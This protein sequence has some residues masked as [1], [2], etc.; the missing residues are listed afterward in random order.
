MLLD[1]RNPLHAGRISR[2]AEGVPALACQQP[3]RNVEKPRLKDVHH[4]GE[5]SACGGSC[6]GDVGDMGYMGNM[7]VIGRREY[8]LFGLYGLYG[9]YGLCGLWIMVMMKGVGR[10]WMC[11]VVWGDE[12]VGKPHLAG[13]VISGHQDCAG[14]VRWPRPLLFLTLLFLL[15]GSAC[16][17]EGWQ[18]QQ[19]WRRQPRPHRAVGLC[20]SQRES[21]RGGV[22]EV[23]GRE[24]RRQRPGGCTFRDRE[25]WLRGLGTAA[26]RWAHTVQPH[27]PRGAERGRGEI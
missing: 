1:V 8:G 16:P 6:E 23:P 12:G 5:G 11:E 22:V 3:L 27:L 14:Q 15:L 13:R 17:V 10:V 24:A 26:S 4:L 7:G 18:R 25:S 20:L 9:L 2:R 21:P 19:P